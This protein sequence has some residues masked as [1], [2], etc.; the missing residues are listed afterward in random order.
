MAL[1]LQTLE[2]SAMVHAVVVILENWLTVEKVVICYIFKITLEFSP[3]TKVSRD[4]GA[5]P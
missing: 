4:N 5:T 1:Y 3:L 2:F